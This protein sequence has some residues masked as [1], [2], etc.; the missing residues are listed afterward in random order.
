MI[1]EITDL[2]P[3]FSSGLNE[4]YLK[5]GD[6]R[7]QELG[8]EMHVPSDKLRYPVSAKVKRYL[9][10]FVSRAYCR[11]R[12]GTSIS[13][14]IDGATVDQWSSQYSTYDKEEGNLRNSLNDWDL[15]SDTYR[16]STVNTGTSTRSVRVLRG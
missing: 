5:K 12:I 1:L 8:E 16:Q 13:Q 4:H 10:V 3:K 15:L 6:D 9:A 14:S 7:Y 2:S 11:D